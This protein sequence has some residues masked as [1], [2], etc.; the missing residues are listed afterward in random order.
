MDDFSA[1]HGEWIKTNEYSTINEGKLFAPGNLRATQDNEG[2]AKLF[3]YWNENQY[4]LR[5][6]GGMVPDVNQIMV[7][8]KGIF[9]N[10]ASKKTKSKLRVLYEVAPIGYIIEKAGGKSSDGE[11]SVLDIPI[12]TTEQVSQVAFG[13]K[14]EV[15]RFNE[16]VG[17][18]YI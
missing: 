14:D 8:G 17:R 13:S 2:Y 3:N 7:K 15:D 16:L 5:Y 10:V 9:V 4:Q 6:T 11:K 1:R 12:T 18:K